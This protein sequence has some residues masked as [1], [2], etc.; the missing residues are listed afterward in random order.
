MAEDHLGQ[1]PESLYKCFGMYLL[2]SLLHNLPSKVL[3]PYFG[4]KS[5]YK[6]WEMLVEK[7]VSKFTH[8]RFIRRQGHLYHVSVFEKSTKNL[9]FTFDSIKVIIHFWNFCHYREAR[10]INTLYIKKLLCAIRGYPLIM[11]TLA[12]KGGGEGSAKC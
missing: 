8:F 6:M 3:A 12:N 9:F 4:R 10:N 7:R 1:I 5:L 11:L 2:R